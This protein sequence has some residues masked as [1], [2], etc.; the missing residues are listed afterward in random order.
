MNLS[1]VITDDEWLA[2]KVMEEYCGRLKGLGVTGVFTDPR[3]AV[4]FISDHK[5]DLLLLDIQMP[6][7]N[8]F[9]LIKK[10]PKPPLIIFTTA[11]HDYA[12]Q[13]FEL[14]VVDYLVKPVAFDRFEKAIQK[15]IEYYSYKKAVRE[16]NR[17]P[18]NFIMI[19]SEYRVIK[20]MTDD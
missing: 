8:G 5:T 4:D 9:E 18:D 2:I 3:K 10:L 7:M 17:Q 20:L 19:R 13:A 16:G 12:V 14:N 11:R 1:V 15:A 6:Y